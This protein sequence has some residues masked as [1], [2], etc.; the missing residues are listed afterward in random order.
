[1]STIED[2][3]NGTEV[4][5]RLARIRR[6]VARRLAAR[7][8]QLS[9]WKDVRAVP[10][11]AIWAGSACVALMLLVRRW[12]DPALRFS[13]SQLGVAATLAGVLAIV[14]RSLLARLEKER[15]ARWI[16]GCAALVAAFPIAA[17]AVG[18]SR[19]PPV[20]AGYVGGIALFVG[21][22][23]WAWSREVVENL[24]AAFFLPP[25]FEHTPMARPATVP[26][27]SAPGATEAASSEKR[28]L[29]WV[30]RAVL[31]GGREELQGALVADFA[32][33]QALATLH[34]PFLPVFPRSP[35]FIC[36]LDD[37]APLRVRSTAV[38]PYGARIELKRTGDTSAA[39]HYEVRFR[40]SQPEALARAA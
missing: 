21:L 37:G 25:T 19:L 7:A 4:G 11:L 1:M 34:V 14:A 8:R 9:A 10:P 29:A 36:D 35:G 17:L 27:R 13:P 30:S 32:P 18:A 38:Y 24:V 33:R 12:N 40:A 31:E 22:A 20:M 28:K 23:A 5:G 16:R 2:R 3:P 39:G 26:F 6:A 15:P